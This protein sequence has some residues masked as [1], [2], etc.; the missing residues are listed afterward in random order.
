ML[1][2]RKQQLWQALTSKHVEDETSQDQRSDDGRDVED[3]TEA[4]PSLSLRIK[5]YLFIEHGLSRFH[6]RE[7]VETVY[8]IQYES[9]GTSLPE[10]I[11]GVAPACK[12]PALNGL[13]RIS[14]SFGG[15]PAG[16]DA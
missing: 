14:S 1:R 7:T 6:T 3:S 2:H 13:C 12:P 11:D 10:S 9:Y 16:L 4:L 5:K 15:T 8:A